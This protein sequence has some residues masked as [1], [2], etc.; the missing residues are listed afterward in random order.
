MNKMKKTKDKDERE[1]AEE[2]RSGGENQG[3]TLGEK[4]D[5]S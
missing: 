5:K 3:I 4:V 1:G 2:R